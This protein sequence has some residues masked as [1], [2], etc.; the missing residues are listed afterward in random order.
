MPGDDERHKCKQ[1]TLLFGVQARDATRERQKIQVWNPG[2][3]ERF[4]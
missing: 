3:N 1:G 2:Q 4:A